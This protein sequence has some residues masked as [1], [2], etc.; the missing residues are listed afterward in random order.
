MDADLLVGYRYG[1]ATGGASLIGVLLVVALAA[2]RDRPGIPE[3]AAT[4]PGGAER[5]T[6]T[7]AS[8]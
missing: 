4:R 3:L 7:P 6:A 5:P 8:R 1:T 2:E